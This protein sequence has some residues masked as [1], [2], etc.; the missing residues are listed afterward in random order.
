M[1]NPATVDPYVGP[2][3]PVG[4]ER[5]QKALVKIAAILFACISGGASLAMGGGSVQSNIVS[6]TASNTYTIPVGAKGWK[7]Y[8]STGTA[9]IGGTPVPTGFSD[10]D[11]GVTTSPIGITMGSASTGYL[12][13]G[14]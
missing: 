6:M 3:A 13:Y 14:S 8:I 7:I 10:G 2:L 1:N 9:T 11:T 4:D 12:R 5:E